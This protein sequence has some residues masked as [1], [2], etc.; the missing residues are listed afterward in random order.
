MKRSIVWIVLVVLLGATVWKLASNKRT[1]EEQVYR[2]DRKAPVHVTVDTVRA[3]A[4]ATGV[5]YSGTIEAVH[6]GR[7]MAEVPGRIVALEVKEGQWVE[8][9]NVIARMDGDLL[10]LQLEAAEVQVEG[11]EKDRQRYAVLTKADAVQGV[12]LEKTELGLRAARIQLGTLQEQMERT[13]IVAPFSGYVAQ[14]FVEVGTVLN[15]SMPVALLSDD[16][17]LEL[18]VAVPGAELG[19]FSKGQEVPM[20]V[21]SSGTPVNG[22]VE[23]VGSRGD[24]AHNFTVRIVL[25]AD[26][27]LKVKPGMAA[28]VLSTPRG[29]AT[30][31]TIPASA[32]FGSTLAPEVYVVS[33]GV[34]QRKRIGTASRDAGR[35]AVSEGLNSGDLVVTGGFINLSDG[36]PVRY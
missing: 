23:S 12:Q 18:V 32:V 8:K 17:S 26:K 33:N 1:Q 21:G 25:Q 13:A 34:A 4:F 5:R 3:I 2:H 9:G 7:V 36:T 29:A 20:F 30:W 27:D 24:M 22:V 14:L 35:V 6:E 16:R 10:R 11:L 19:A 28:S 15:P 31:P